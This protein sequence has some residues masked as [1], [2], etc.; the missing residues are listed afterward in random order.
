M[1]MRV[2]NDPGASLNPNA[3]ERAG[4]RAEAVLPAK[5]DTGSPS[6]APRPVPGTDM[7]LLQGDLEPREGTGGSRHH[8]C[9]GP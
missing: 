6:W 1:H 8:F 2:G 3:S 5:R 9:A 7:H 4:R